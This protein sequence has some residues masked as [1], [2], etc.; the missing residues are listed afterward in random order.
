MLFIII[1]S[2]LIYHIPADQPKLNNV[3][4]N[5]YQYFTNKQGF[6]LALPKSSIQQ[7]FNELS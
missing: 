4:A 1:T 7:Y 3:W 6:L 5:I 2:Y